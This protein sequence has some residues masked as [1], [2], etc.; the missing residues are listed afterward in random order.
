MKYSIRLISKL[1][2]SINFWL[3]S[4]C[5]NYPQDDA[6]IKVFKIKEVVIENF[7]FHFQRI[8]KITKGKWF[9]TYF[10]QIDKYETYTHKRGY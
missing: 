5:T 3:N 6:P 9:N 10:G 4:K 8:V 7:H 1:K 2:I